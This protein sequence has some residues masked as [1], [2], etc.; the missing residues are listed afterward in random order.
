MLRLIVC[1]LAAVVGAGFASGRE[2]IRFFSRWGSLSWPLILLCALAAGWM[3]HRLLERSAS[4]F[5]S[6]NHPASGLV[7]VLLLAMY[8]CVSGGMAASAGELAALTIPI[9]YA[10][11][12]GLLFT[13]FTCVLLSK[14]PGA[15]L[16]GLGCALIPLLIAAW[17]LCLKIPSQLECPA[18]IYLPSSIV[19]APMLTLFYCAMNMT[20]AAGVI[21]KLA[22]QCTE[23]QKKRLSAGVGIGFG[24]MLTL[25]NAA[26]L[27]HLDALADQPLPTVMLLR[28]Y[29]KTGFYLSASV[30]YLAVS[31]TLIAALSAARELLPRRIQAKAGPVLFVLS[32]LIA[33]LGFTRIVAWA[34]PILGAFGLMTMLP[35]KKRQQYASAQMPDRQESLYNS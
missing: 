32:A 25:G 17:T 19:T 2:I 4:I 1:I 34:Y 6:N 24:L 20:L 31:T 7:S 5:P 33:C 14:R 8:L 16:Q 26:L 21:N 3:T 10:R 28:G 13:L 27:P 12:L 23:M 29:G 11:S 30:L 9:H 22:A 18:P 35:K 15:A